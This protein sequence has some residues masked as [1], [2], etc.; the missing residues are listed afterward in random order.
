MRS[1]A[2]LDCSRPGAGLRQQLRSIDGRSPEVE[3]AWLTADVAAY[4]D[5]A[6]DPDLKG[7]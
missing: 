1:L 2:H 3:Q 5:A 4:S 6:V 7:R